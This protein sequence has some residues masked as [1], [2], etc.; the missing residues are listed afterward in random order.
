M[1]FVP[2]LKTCKPLANNLFLG[3]LEEI[4]WLQYKNGCQKKRFY[5]MQKN[6]RK[7]LKILSWSK[8]IKIKQ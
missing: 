1:N 3:I 2:K 5:A 4:G 6:N 7:R 8:R